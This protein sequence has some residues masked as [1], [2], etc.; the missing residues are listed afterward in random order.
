MF[1]CTITG[2]LIGSIQQDWSLLGPKYSILNSQGQ[3]TLTIKGPFRSCGS[4]CA[5]DIVFRVLSPESS[6]EEIGKISKSWTGELQETPT[7][8][9]VFAI[10]FPENLDVKTKAVLL[11]A[12]FL[13]DFMY[14]TKSKN[15]PKN[16]EE[17]SNSQTKTSLQSN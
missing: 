15:S 4:I 14:F 9:D 11:A 6:E 12:C 17:D 8:S 16:P 5:G 2:N 13:I 3:K 7:D 10:T 1:F